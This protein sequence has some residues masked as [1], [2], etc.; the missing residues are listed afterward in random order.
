MSCARGVDGALYPVFNW[1]TV[2]L[3]FSQLAKTERGW[4]MHE[5]LRQWMR[6][7]HEG[8]SPVRL[9][10]LWNPSKVSKGSDGQ[11]SGEVRRRQ[12]RQ[13]AQNG[14]VTVDTLGLVKVS[15]RLPVWVSVTANKSSKQVK[16][17]GQAMSRGVSE[18]V[19]Q[20]QLY[21]CSRAESTTCCHLSKFC[22]WFLSE[23]EERCAPFTT[24][25]HLSTLFMTGINISIWDSATW[26]VV[27]PNCLRSS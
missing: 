16:Q 20:C 3:I 15:G 18:C 17:M 2:Y 25:L 19:K 7:A 6:V 5:R 10:P 24:P 4:G 12:T 22:W 9:K 8:D 1:Q 13:G 11:P 26:L 21:C 23:F 27:F 14:F